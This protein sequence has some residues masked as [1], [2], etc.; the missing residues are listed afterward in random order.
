MVNI[1]DTVQRINP[2]QDPRWARFIQRHPRASAFHSLPWLEA[3]YKT[4]LYEPVVYTTSAEGKELE[5]G[6]LFC[7]VQSWLTGRRLVS[8]PFSD[9]CEPLVKDRQELQQLLARSQWD[10]NQDG[11]QYLEMR[12]LTNSYVDDLEGQYVLHLLDL[13]PSLDELY[14]KL[15]VSSV[16]RKIQRGEREG[17]SVES[18]SAEYLLN[19]FYHLHVMT[20]KRQSI[21]PHPRMWFRQLLENF[22][23]KAIIRVA[24]TKET[25]VA[26]VMTVESNQSIIYKYGCSDAR[27]HNLGG[28]PFVFWNMIRDAK[29]RGFVQLDL[30]RSELRHTGL[31]AFKD[32]WG[33]AKQKLIYSRYPTPKNNVS[34]PQAT[35]LR[36]AKAIFRRSPE[37]VLT[38]TAKLLYPHIG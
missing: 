14:K 27:F 1:T 18:G 17:L 13:R 36:M 10:L 5:N 25:P 32:R 20:R 22:Q 6:L 15:Q 16:R 38:M 26:A 7:K 37:W 4:Y 12:P 31:I 11:W 3:L 9:H 28:V 8:L 30:G 23:G 2:L 19:Q 33:A 29:E 21:P 24:K 34:T 35:T